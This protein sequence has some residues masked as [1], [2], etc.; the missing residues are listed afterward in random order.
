[1]K[2]HS[3]DTIN[4]TV[5]AEHWTHA[6]ALLMDAIATPTQAAFN[7]VRDAV[8]KAEV[9]AY[10]PAEARMVQGLVRVVADAARDNGYRFND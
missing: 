5:F 10:G 9:E 3:R 4:P 7:A 1:M 2:Y 6:N 8:V